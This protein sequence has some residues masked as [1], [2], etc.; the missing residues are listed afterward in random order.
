MSKRQEKLTVSQAL[1]KGYTLCGKGYTDWQ[2][3]DDIK[4]MS[5]EDLVDN[6]TYIFSKEDEFVYPSIKEGEIKSFI[7]DTLAAQDEAGYRNDTAIEDAIMEMDLSALTERINAKMKKDFR[8]YI[9]TD[10]LLIAGK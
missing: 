9:Q 5:D 10:V 8:N 3:L 6:D 1:A 2:V 7:G 4:D